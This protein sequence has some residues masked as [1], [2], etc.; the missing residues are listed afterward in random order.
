MF[1]NTGLGRDIIKHFS[2]SLMADEISYSAVS[3]ISILRQSTILWILTLTC[4][5]IVQ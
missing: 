1:Y 2:S 3:C 5:N 4:T